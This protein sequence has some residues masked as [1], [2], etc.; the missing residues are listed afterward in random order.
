[1][2]LF[3]KVGF[4]SPLFASL[5]SLSIFY[6]FETQIFLLENE[7]FSTFGWT[8]EHST[9]LVASHTPVIGR[10]RVDIYSTNFKGQLLT[11]LLV[12]KIEFPC[13]IGPRTNAL[14]TQDSRFYFAGTKNDIISSIDLTEKSVNKGHYLVGLCTSK[15]ARVIFY[16]LRGQIL[17]EGGQLSVGSVQTKGGLR[18]T[19]SGNVKGGIQRGPERAF[20]VW[21]NNGNIIYLHD[22][23]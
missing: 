22:K 16:E 5:Q 19:C 11:L 12:N 6:F 13:F 1:M 17:R 2:I 15:S 8:K 14:D 9:L 3:K 20:W 23:D 21:S 7:V 10:N 18:M 4:A